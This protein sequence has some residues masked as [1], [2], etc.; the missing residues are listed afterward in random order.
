MRRAPL[1]ERT[2]CLQGT[3]EDEAFAPLL[4]CAEHSAERGG[5][6]ERATNDENECDDDDVEIVED[7]LLERC[8]FLDLIDLPGQYDARHY[9]GNTQQLNKQTNAQATPNH[10]NHTTKRRARV[11]E[12]AAVLSA[13]AS[14]SDAAL[15]TKKRML[16]PMT[17]LRAN[18]SHASAQFLRPRPAPILR[19]HTAQTNRRHSTRQTRETRRSSIDRN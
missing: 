7:C 15:H 6:N 8:L 9:N 11:S 16:T 2:Q 13:G 5:D 12:P 3:Y 17:I 1:R 4:P 10:N 19:D 14:E 18:F